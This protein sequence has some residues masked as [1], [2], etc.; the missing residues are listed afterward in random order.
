QHSPA[1][2]HVVPSI[3]QAGAASTEPSGIGPSPTGASTAP[4]LPPVA[5]PEPPT[6]LVPPAPARP[7]A[8]PPPSP[9]AP[10]FV[11]IALSPQPMSSTPA[12]PRAGPTDRRLRRCMTASRHKANRSNQHCCRGDYPPQAIILRLRE[13]SQCAL[14]DH[15]GR[16]EPWGNG[17]L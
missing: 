14:E 10:P 3:R 7:P 6:P 4:P 11:P 15:L 12:S 5:P 1:P 2:E 13:S 16:R 17:L 8:P 9:P